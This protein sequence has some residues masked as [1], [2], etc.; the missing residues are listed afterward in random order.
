MYAHNVMLAIHGV[1]KVFDKDSLPSWSGGA[2]GQKCD[3]WAPEM[4][5]KL[6]SIK[7]RSMSCIR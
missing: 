3:Y 2:H 1:R 7:E 5:Q 6:D 4:H